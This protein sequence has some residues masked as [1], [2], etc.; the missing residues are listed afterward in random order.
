MP[1]PNSIPPD[2]RHRL[3]NVLSR[4]DRGAPELWGEIREWLAEHGVEA[5]ERLPE[6]PQRPAVRD[7]H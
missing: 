3:E 4:R 6:D 1:W 5:P 2:L 7:G